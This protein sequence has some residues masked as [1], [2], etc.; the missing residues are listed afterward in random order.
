MSDFTHPEVQK[1]G[2]ISDL[3]IKHITLLAIVFTSSISCS[4]SFPEPTPI[5]AEELAS[6]HEEWRSKREKRL[7]TPP[8]GPVLWYGLFEIG[9]GETGFGSDPSL[10]ITLPTEDSPPSAGTLVRTKQE[11]ILHTNTGAEIYLEDGTPIED[12]IVLKNNRSEN[13]TYLS[14]GSLGMRIHSEP[15]TDRL[16][17][18]VWKTK[19]DENQVFKLPEFFT[20]STEWLVPARLKRYSSPRP[21]P[22]ADVTGGMI[23]KEAIGELVFS[24]NNLEHRLI[25]TGNKKSKSYFVS[26]WDST[27][28]TDTYQSGRYLSVPKVNKDGWTTIDFNRA[29]NPPCVFTEFSV[30][31]LPPPDNRLKLSVTAGEKRPDRPYY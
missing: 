27:A 29:Y 3:M 22:L 13:T 1:M 20:V 26:M 28:I 14:L 21:L 30:C 18:R 4:N 6:E 5:T 7:V 8:G 19:L 16:W 24:K 25:V 15:G 31:S 12:K 23:E 10:S 9:Q 11:V 17:L 2:N